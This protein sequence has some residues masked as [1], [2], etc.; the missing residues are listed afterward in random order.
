AQ[1]QSVSAAL[2]SMLKTR[3]QDA[4]SSPA[5]ALVEQV[6]RLSVQ[7]DGIDQGALTL[8]LTKPIKVLPEP[9][10]NSVVLTST[11]DNV[12]A[13][14]EVVKLLDRLP[15]GDAVV[16]RFFPLANASAQRIAGIMRELFNQGDRLRQTP[17]TQ[18]RG[19][20]ATEV[21]KALA[22]QVAVS[23]D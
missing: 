10:T 8:D 20:P 14:A 3:P 15:V 11:K 22:S 18:I 4:V 6:R 9:Q 12:A 17:A 13:L 23:T 1:A 5:A 7:R 2:D 21:G 19:E 16:V